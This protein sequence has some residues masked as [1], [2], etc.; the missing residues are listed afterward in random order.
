MAEKRMFAKTIIDSDLFLDMPMSTQLLYFHLAM[1][2]DDDGFV[3]SPKK[4]QR[5]VGCNDDDI[6]ILISKQFLIP[7]ESGV[8]VIKHW[9]IHNY[10]RKDTYNETRYIEEKK[11]LSIDEDKTYIFKSEIECIPAVNVPS[12]ERTPTV[13]TDKNRLDKISEEKKSNM[14]DKSD[15]DS[16]SVKRKSKKSQIELDFEECWSIYPKKQGKADARKAYIKFAKK[17]TELKEKVIAGIK[18]YIEHIRKNKIEYQFIKYG[19]TYFNGEC[20]YDEYDA[21]EGEENGETPVL[22]GLV[23]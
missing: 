14:S 2:A 4:I 20:W 8:V 15:N 10:I 23:F 9:K 5:M 16:V 17:D 22:R 1:R 13:D 21:E 12:T 18:K 19:S 7:F 3:N 11:Q 6:R